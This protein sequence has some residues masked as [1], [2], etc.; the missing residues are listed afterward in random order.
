MVK[1]EVYFEFKG[2]SL[3]FFKVEE[4]GEVL[5]FSRKR[6]K[7]FFIVMEEDKVIEFRVEK[8]GKDVVVVVFF[9]S[10]C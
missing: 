4:E 7:F 1:E 8:L 10:E 3:K 2:R 5:E 6:L 9:N